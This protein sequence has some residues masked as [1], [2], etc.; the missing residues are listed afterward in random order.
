M[1]VTN[2]E[3]LIKN[4]TLLFDDNVV[5]MGYGGAIVLLTSTL[6]ICEHAN[7]SFI[8]NTASD[9]GG[10]IFQLSD[11]SLII[12]TS[13]VLILH[14]NSA[15]QGGAI[16]TLM[17]TSINVQALTVEA[18]KTGKRDYIYH[19]AMFDPHTAA[20]LSLDQIHRLVDELLLAH[21]DWLPTFS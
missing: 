18:L 10:A 5:H 19:A 16:Y 6:K 1:Y 15:V 20:E 9:E 8:N 17:Q 3:V 13:S 7:V 11:G 2:S 4:A 21:A 14:N 12:N